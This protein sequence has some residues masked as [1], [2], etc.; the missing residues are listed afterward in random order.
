MS[1]M[2]AVLERLRMAVK[3]DGVI[4]TYDTNAE[5]RDKANISSNL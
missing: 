2:N 1:D 3:V 4:V 5:E